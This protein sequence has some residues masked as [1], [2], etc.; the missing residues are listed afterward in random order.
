M[1]NKFLVKRSNVPGKVPVES[2]L[3]V[4]ELAINFADQ[5]LYTK[6]PAGGIV[7]MSITGAQGP[8]GIQGEQGIQ[9]I[10]G[11]PG[12]NG[13]N[14]E[15]GA[16]G[17][18]GEKGDQGIQGIQGEQGDT[19]SQ[20][21][22]GAD[23]DTGPQGI[24][25]I[26]GE[27]GTHGTDGVDGATGATG[28]Q[29]IQGPQGPQGDAGADGT[30]VELK[31]SV[32]DFSSLPA[33][34]SEGDLW[35]TS[36]TGDGWVSDGAGGWS[37][38]G[39]I[40][41]PAGA[42]GPQGDTGAQGPQGPQGDA[43]ATGATGAQGDQGI[44]GVAGADGSDGATGPAG[45]DGA[46]GAPGATGAQGP[47]G[48]QGI[49]GDQGPA[50]ADGT[51]G[52]D[53]AQG[54]QGEPG[55]DGVDGTDGTDGTN[56]APGVD[57]TKWFSGSG[58]PSSVTGAVNN[59]YYLDGDSGLVYILRPQG[60]QFTGYSLEGPQGDQGIQGIQGEKG[61]KGDPGT[62]GSGLPEFFKFMVGDKVLIVQTGQSNPQG[63]EARRAAAGVDTWENNRVWDWQ[64]SD[65]TTVQQDYTNFA[66]SRWDWVNPA[67][68]Q[69]TAQNF[70][71]ALMYMGYTGGN[72]GNQVYALANE[73]QLS[74]D[75]DVYVVNLCQGG[76]SIEW[77]E[78]PTVFGINMAEVL[79]DALQYLLAGSSGVD[80]QEK[81]G[82]DIVTWGQSEANIYA[83]MGTFPTTP[84]DW[85]QRLDVIFDLAKSQANSWIADGYSKIFLTEAT[86]Y[87]NWDGVP[88]SA[89]YAGCPYRWN[90]ANVMATKYGDDITLVS[91]RGIEHGDGVDPSMVTA[92]PV[93]QAGNPTYLVHYSGDGNDA[94]GRRIADIVLGRERE[95]KDTDADVMNGE[96]QTSVEQQSADIA[97]NTSL[98]GQ[99]NVSIATNTADIAINTAGV[100]TNTA[101]IATNTAAIAALGGELN[102]VQ[103]MF[104]PNGD[105]IKVVT[106]LLDV[107]S[108][109][110]YNVLDSGSMFGNCP[111][112]VFVSP[113][114]NVSEDYGLYT[115]GG[116]MLGVASANGITSME[117]AAYPIVGTTTSK[118]KFGAKVARVSTNSSAQRYR[119][120][121]GWMRPMDASNTNIGIY[122]E[123]RYKN[124]A[125][126]ANWW[127]VVE[128][129]GNRVEVDMGVSVTQRQ[130]LL[131]VC[132]SLIVE[133]DAAT[134]IATFTVEKASTT[135]P[136][137]PNDAPVTKTLSTTIMASGLTY[138]ASAGVLLEKTEGAD[139]Q[140]AYVDFM[141][142]DT[143][144]INDVFGLEAFV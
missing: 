130:N 107:A 93:A 45:A 40:Q 56:G 24:Q 75:L 36:D 12:T 34:A 121:A 20:G 76:A 21:P 82:P 70:S 101:D 16:Q 129:G 133:Y 119:I 39:P 131:G 83:P 117:L 144:M 77:W 33:G 72:T 141:Y 60:W 115:P 98:I 90:G 123:H 19:G 4:G 99:A 132:D 26:Q 85:A 106:H 43:G 102:P 91:S 84:E 31:G 30:S 52:T 59:D 61:D 10:Q 112:R 50:G 38:V 79:Q 118:F 127:G 103:K 55:N 32:A 14:G 22:A 9:G 86:D 126:D 46:D 142:V 96:V 65:R 27:P 23:G 139:L 62:S 124:Q 135:T 122:M 73:V 69:T 42:T 80:F 6:E 44:Q 125:G 41:G 113:T 71:A 109:A 28:P 136:P 111:V 134:N 105:N 128:N 116:A 47:Q 54:I 1:S 92:A 57:G 7:D 143:T 89:S 58:A 67:T 68:T 53:G 15:N 35:I 97:S 51:D 18:Q 94:Y 138:L 8:Q 17:I 49:Q 74:T 63:L 48:D 104:G 81:P 11:E 78:T 100:A 140:E 13:T 29:G 64:W 88:G 2:D 5:K 37:N 114:G 137:G 108:N 95:F 120:C 66:D 25:G 87:V 110:S 3:E